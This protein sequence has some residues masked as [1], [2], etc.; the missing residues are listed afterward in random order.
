MLPDRPIQHQLEDD[1][2]KAFESIVPSRHVY[3]REEHPEYG[4]DGE[5]EEFN[6][7]NQATGRRFKV[8]L[9][10]TTEAGAAAMR[11][12]IRL[13]TAAYYH[14]QELSVLMVRYIAETGSLYGRWFHRFDPYYEHVGETHLT[15]HWSGDDALTEASFDRLFGEVERMRRLKRAG[16]RLPLSVA[17]ETPAEGAHGCT[18]GELELAVE[19]AVA[20]C[21]GVLER[22]AAGE[23]TDVTVAVDN[24]EIRAD[25]VGIKSMTF[26]PNETDYPP[27]GSAE[28][29]A[30]EALTC[31]AAALGNAGHGEPA[32][33]IAVHFLADSLVSGIPPISVRLGAA[34]ADAG[35]IVEVIDLAERLD[36][37]DDEARAACGAMFMQLVGERAESLQKDEV[38][39]YE[40]ALRARLQR[41]LDA[42]RKHEAAGSAENLGTY[43][44]VARRPWDAVG[45]LEQ[46]LALDPGRETAGTARQLA[47]A[48]FLSCRYVESIAAYD[49]ALELAEQAEP[50][51]EALR[52]DALLYAGRYRQAL[53]AFAE[54]ETDDVKFS[55]WVYVKTRAL[56]WVLRATGI[57]EQ[58]PNPKAANEVAGRF[59]EIE[60]DRDADELAE[61]VW[62]LHAVS[63]LGW[64]N[65]ARDLLDQGREEDAMHAYLTAAVMR[66]GDVEAWVNVA[67]LAGNL[68]DSDL[69][70]TSVISGERLNDDR[71]MGYLVNHL[72]KTVPDPGV[73]EEMLRAVRK[74]I[75][76]AS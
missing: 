29:V 27:E 7:S 19:A 53:D 73:R 71:Y 28:M 14:A 76:A 49:R 31:V 43:L 26:H 16:P 37:A 62:E 36:Q 41:R 52:A 34:M 1:S 17:I 22:A 54:I 46:E 25:L 51:W 65:R 9:K 6:E 30:A 75:A 39:R 12:R 4:I 40:A 70:A 48:Y 18:R 3:R 66:E 69:F 55:A 2:R 38:D 24:D 5:L 68:G 67:L 42:G 45:F 63:P 15:F 44:M 64:F 58:D 50:R 61:R 10:A 11:E 47:G 13:K 72:R 8:Q 56:T 20:R 32:A 74:T 33:R 57:E 60:S 59:A 35:R 23:Q 21:R